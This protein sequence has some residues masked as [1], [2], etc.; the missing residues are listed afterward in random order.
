MSELEQI[1]KINVPFGGIYPKENGFDTGRIAMPG[2]LVNTLRRRQKIEKVD[3]INLFYRVHKGE[4]IKYL[5][6]TDYIPRKNNNFLHYYF[7]DGLG[8][9]N[10]LSIP[11]VVLK[12]IDI[13]NRD[14]IVLLGLGDYMVIC[15][16][17]YYRQ[18][19]KLKQLDGV[20]C[21]I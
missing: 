9:N 10:S 19:E 20:F 17:K 14:P 6:I 1:V 12:E 4:A 16:T 18:Y 21:R 2:Q 11:F 15:K 5:E 7:I 3:E 8:S 13:K